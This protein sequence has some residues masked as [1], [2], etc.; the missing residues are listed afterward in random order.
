[1]KTYYEGVEVDGSQSPSSDS[2][3]RS[4]TSAITRS[5]SYAKVRDSML[6]SVIRIG[7]QAQTQ[8]LDRNHEADSM[9]EN[10]TIRKQTSYAS[11]YN[12]FDDFAPSQCQTIRFQVIIWSIE[13]PDVRNNRV[14]MKFR[15]TLFWNDD[16][17]KK[18]NA[19]RI[20]NIDQ[21]GDGVST[22]TRSRSQSIWVMV[23]RSAATKKKIS[24]CSTD[25]IDV[26]PVSILNADFLDVIGQPEVQVL[27]EGSRLMR[28]SCMYR[29]QLHQDDMRV[30]E[31]PHDAHNLSLNLGILSQRQPGG[32]WGKVVS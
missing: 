27:R 1:M 12:S 11:P 30:C 29:A 14:S 32:R 5:R 15:V 20:P 4:W 28:W 25:T 31:F 13:C 19:T 26:P 7:E 23:G 8:F 22:N 18:E 17:P 10:S 21:Q 6:D 3:R 16:P 24:E 9:D 2:A